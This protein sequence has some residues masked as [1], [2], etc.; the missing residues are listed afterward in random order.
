MLFCFENADETTHPIETIWVQ[1][2]R[3]RRV[4]IFRVLVCCLA[5]SRAQVMVIASIIVECVS[6]Y[7][8]KLFSVKKSDYVMLCTIVWRQ[9]QSIIFKNRH[10]LKNWH[11]FFFSQKWQARKRKSQVGAREKFT[12]KFSQKFSFIHVLI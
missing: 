3:R 9:Y 4:D 11:A 12:Q 5:M 6:W 8:S 7:F 1:L 10:V 2:E